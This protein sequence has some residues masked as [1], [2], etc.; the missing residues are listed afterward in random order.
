MSLLFI[1]GNLLLWAL[2][3]LTKMA[4][5][6]MP[7]WGYDDDLSTIPKVNKSASDWASL[8]QFG[9]FYVYMGAL[10]FSIWGFFGWEVWINIFFVF[11]NHWCGVEDLL[12][13][14][15]SNV[16]KLPKEY[17]DSHP[18]YLGIPD[19][20]YW[21]SEPRIVL[22]IKIPSIIGFVCGKDVPRL[23]FVLLTVSVIILIIILGVIL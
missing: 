10:A 20:L 21:L 18:N 6:E 4:K 13:F 7:Y 22:G 9:L 19:T 5:S 11:L 2:Y 14:L 15:L 1:Y 3:D 23:K 17:T 16:I 12:Y 8:T